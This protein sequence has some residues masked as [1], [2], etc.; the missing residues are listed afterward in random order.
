MTDGA[1]ATQT[2]TTAREATAPRGERPVALVTGGSRGIGA[3]TALA[4]AARR[5][6]PERVGWA[7]AC[8]AGQ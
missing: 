6:D 8:G 5:A 1:D 3:E 2:D 7:G 4:L